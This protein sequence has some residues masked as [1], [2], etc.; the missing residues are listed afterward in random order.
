MAATQKSAC[1]RRLEDAPVRDGDDGGLR[2]VAGAVAVALAVVVVV[3]V[4][5]AVEV[6]IS[7]L[8]S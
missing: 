3:A 1:G 7:Q 2:I 4:A 8:K 6:C 5:A